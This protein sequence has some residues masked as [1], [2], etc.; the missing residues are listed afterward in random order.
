M[1]IF[2]NKSL[3]KKIAIVLLIVTIFSFCFSGKVSASDDGTGGKLLSPIVDLFVFLGDGVMDI[4]H[5]A[6]FQNSHSTI[7]IDMGSTFWEVAGTILIGIVTAVVVAAAVIVTAGAVVAAVAA[8]GVTLSAVGVGTVLLIS[9]GSGVAAASYF[10][11]NVLPD[12]VYLPVYQISPDQIF[13]NEVL[14]F[15]V[16]FF[17]PS[18]DKELKDANG[19]VLYGEDNNPIVLESVA[20]QLRSVISNWYTTLRDIAIVAL[21][22]ILVYIGIRIIISS[23]SSDKSKYKQMLMDWVVAVCLLFVMQYIMAFSNLIVKRVTEAVKD[24]K[25]DN[26]YFT[27]IEDEDGKIEEA[28]D[29]MG[30]DTSSLVSDG[31]VV[32][33]TNLLGFARLNAQMAKKDNTSYAGYALIFVVLVLFTC[34]FIFTYLK[35]VLYMAFLTL[36][37]PLVAMTYPIDKI[38]DGKAQ[39]FNMW[40]KEYIFNLLIQPMHLLL[41]TIL[42]S[43][44]FELAATNIIYSLVAL[45]F[46]MPAEKLLRRFFGFEKAHTPGLLA[47]PAGAA[48][49]MSGMNKLLSK[50]PKGGKD[51][52]KGGKSDDDNN[53]KAPRVNDNFDKDSYLFSGDENKKGDSAGRQDSEILKASDATQDME[54]EQGKK[55]A[56]MTSEQEGQNESGKN[57]EKDDDFYYFDDE[58]DF[59]ELYSK[60]EEPIRTTEPDRKTREKGNPNEKNE[61]MS[62]F[63]RKLM[64]GTLDRGDHAGQRRRKISKSKTKSKNN[65]FLSS[66]G[67]VS[68]YYARGMANNMKKGLK[69]KV[70]NFH[71]VQSA[72][73]FT[74]KAVGGATLGAAGLAI[75][76]TSGD[77]SKAVQY[78]TAGAVGGY[79]MAGGFVNKFDSLTPDGVA[80]VAQ[81]ARY[82]SEDDYEKAKQ[83]KYKKDYQRNEKNRFELERRFGK[84]E[85][86][87]IMK[88]DIPTLLDNGVTKMEDISTIETMLQEGQIKKVEEGIAIKKYASRINENSRN[89]TEKKRDEWRKTFSKEFGKK[90]K[91]KNQNHDSMADSVLDKVDAYNKIKF[92]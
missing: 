17:N 62:E 66:A 50:G 13:A 19:N 44:A 26:G 51:S 86:N 91:Y 76:I 12:D 2:E 77:L 82:E 47:G 70:S 32:W 55:P 39:A 33:N 38:N 64:D 92:K 6:I 61:H 4:I 1:K 42:V 59:K 87:R 85:A 63:A 45:G 31:K 79:K 20:K 81:R 40:F 46:M 84:K 30:Y 37:A 60:V 16:D 54:E 67:A 65:G 49:M 69:N 73:R 83:E 5:G 11:S 25:Y 52:S 10:S 78:T 41:Y 53:E 80:E 22:S 74:A 34:Y 9:V 21:L 58:D 71:P 8:L 24:I 89:M 29:E 23:T 88:D 15:D 75:G 90:E 48:L 57:K 36:I 43:S 28:L 3:L 68:R 72:T 7:H 18:P 56:T 27:V 35:R 14:L